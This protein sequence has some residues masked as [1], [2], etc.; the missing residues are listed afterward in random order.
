MS[1][2]I[3]EKKQ[4]RSKAKSAVTLASRRL[5]NAANRDVEFEVLKGLMTDLERVYD[6]FF[7]VNEEFEELVL[8]E[9]HAEH[10]TV[11]GESITEYTRNVQRCYEEARH[12]FV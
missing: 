8:P 6:D 5:T 2:Q 7:C 11:N 1:E 10:R 9:E 3:Q 4:E 12:V